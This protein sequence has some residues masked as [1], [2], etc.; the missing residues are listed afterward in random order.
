[1]THIAVSILTV[2]NNRSQFSSSAIVQ[3][4]SAIACRRQAISA[5]EIRCAMLVLV[6]VHIEIAVLSDRNGTADYNAVMCWYNLQFCCLPAYCCSH[7][8]ITA[9]I[10]FSMVYYSNCAYAS[11]MLHSVL[12]QSL[13]TPIGSLYQE[14]YNAMCSTIRIVAMSHT[15]SQSRMCYHIKIELLRRLIDCVHHYCLLYIGISP[16]C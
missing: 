10:Y 14:L 3:H 4:A 6:S 15:T 11:S 8:A 7:K 16:L 13:H 12:L 2:Y 9:I 5:S 1:V